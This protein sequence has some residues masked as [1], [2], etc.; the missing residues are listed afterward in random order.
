MILIITN[1]NHERHCDWTL[2][3]FSVFP[4]DTICVPGVPGCNTGVPKAQVPLSMASLRA[5]TTGTGTT[6][7]H[8]AS[9]TAT[10]I[11]T[12][13]EMQ[14]YATICNDMQRYATNTP[15]RNDS[16]SQHLWFT[17]D[18]LMLNHCTPCLKTRLSPSYGY[19]IRIGSVARS[20]PC[21]L[22]VTTRRFLMCSSLI[23]IC[24]L[25]SWYGQRL[26]EQIRFELVSFISAIRFNMI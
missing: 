18:L 15:I 13:D 17:V 11:D 5:L 1:P 4:A 24:H 6:G 22:H 19:G 16:N 12:G 23:G 9:Q 3:L 25:S 21:E 8:R 14:R 20:A 2:K 7:D 26:I 10:E